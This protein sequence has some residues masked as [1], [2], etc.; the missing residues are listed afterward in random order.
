M[1]STDW[2]SS[3]W[4]AALVALAS[5]KLALLVVA[6]DF[7]GR[8]LNPFDL[9][10]SVFGR[11]LEWVMCGI[12]LIAVAQWGRAL[13]RQTN[14]HLAVGLFLVANL[15]SAGFAENPYVAFF[16]AP[17]KYL[18]VSFLIDMAV[19]YFA[20]AAAFRRGRDWALLFAAVV[21][22][23]VVSAV[24]TWVQI[25]GRDPLSWSMASSVR[26]FSTVG[27]PDTYAHF[28]SVV[29]ATSAGALVLYRG[30]R[31]GLVRG[32]VTFVGLMALLISGWVASRAVVFGVAV[33]VIVPPLMYW[34]LSGRPV[35]RSQPARLGLALAAATLAVGVALSPLGQ[36]LLATGQGGAVG[37]RVV[38]WEAALRAF[39]DR[40]LLGYGVD[41]FGVIWPRYRTQEF[42]RLAP[43]STNDSAH[44]WLLQTAATTGLLGIASLLGLQFLSFH[45]LAMRGSQTFPLVSCLL[46]LAAA[47]Y[48]AH[49]LVSVGTV[50]VDWVPWVVAGG[51]A[52][53]VV[54]Q[55]NRVA[56]KR[57]VP[58]LVSAVVVAGAIAA[59]ATGLSAFAAN[60][61]AL[62]TRH[63]ADI[64]QG[65]DAIGHGLRSV[66]L[67]S[68]RADYWNE[69]GRGYFSARRWIDAADAFQAAHERLPS[70]PVFLSNMART[71][72]Q[73]ARLGDTSHGGPAAA[74]GAA[75]KAVDLDPNDPEPRVALADVAIAVGSPDVAL[76]AS[77]EAFRLLPDAR[78]VRLAITAAPTATDLGSA[79]EI[80]EMMVATS[81]SPALRVSIAQIAVRQGDRVAAIANAKRALQLEPNNATALAIVRDL[82]G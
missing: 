41:N 64:G 10:K 36:R 14:L 56:T 54:G 58:T 79:R 29:I 72:A 50:A 20:V 65:G 17:G 40:P 53:L 62:A 13:W 5:L 68:G 32:A 77:A 39:V 26:P 82:G 42:V 18:G 15:V 24:Y 12:L 21:V 44:S 30:P 49:G 4:R 67:D 60:R 48:W 34:R 2:E 3:R 66:A 1:S 8:A 74:I 28:L 6:F 51:A 7:T 23:F 22:A 52:A 43:V 78:S 25:L 19:L 75:E 69:L 59:G 46:M 37:E 31:S 55:P 81:E 57:R 11:W 16:G 71:L 38:V 35:V 45:T 27:N 33:A 80:L 73:L 76:R 63:A 47:G 70:D 61:E 9:T